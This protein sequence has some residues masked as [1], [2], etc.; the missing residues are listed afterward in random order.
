MGTLIARTVL[1]KAQ[2]IL[3]DQTGVLW[4]LDELIAWFNEG[5]RRV[6]LLRPDSSSEIKEV[7]LQA[8]TRQNMPVGSIRLLDVR[9]NVDGRACTYIKRSSLDFFNSGWR[10]TTAGAT[11][12]HWLYDELVPHEFEVYPPQ[13]A[14]GFGT[15]EM[16]RS[17]LPT[18]C[19]LAGVSG[20]S[21]NSVIGLPDQYEAVLVD[22]TVYRGYSKDATY[23]VRGGK[24][25]MAWNAFLQGLGI[26]LT[27][28]RRFAPA[29]TMPP[30]MSEQRPSQGAFP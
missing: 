1:L 10:T 6:V 4:G 19:T 28:D 23:T 5:Q 14:S 26:Q 29:N 17:I 9:C 7:T 24:A 2:R 8:G 11:V 21:V 20:E 16:V 18:D 27:T 3:N 25:E 22:Y 15:I 30:H 13:P 12:K